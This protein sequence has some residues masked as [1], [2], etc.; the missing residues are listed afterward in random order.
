LTVSLCR[1]G[2]RHHRASCSLDAW[3]ERSMLPAWVAYH[4]VP[5]CKEAFAA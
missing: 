2:C 4:A 3:S 5:H 1:H